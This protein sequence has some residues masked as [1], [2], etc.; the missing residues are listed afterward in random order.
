MEELLAQDISAH[1][2]MTKLKFDPY[3]QK[4]FGNAKL[5]TLS[6][7]VDMFNK[8]NPNRK[9][10][11][12]DTLRKDYSEQYLVLEFQIA[13]NNGNEVTKAMATKLQTE[14]FEHWV[15]NKKTASDVFND[16]GF[17]FYF[18]NTR[19]TI[20]DDYV[21]V[22]NAKNPHHKTKTLKVLIDGFE[23]EDKLAIRLALNVPDGN[24]N[25]WNLLFQD[26]VKRK[27]NPMSVLV[28]VFK[29]D[30]K[31]LD[32][33]SDKIKAIIAEYKPFYLEK[34]RVDPDWLPKNVDPRRL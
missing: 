31:K 19:L 6:D 17:Q 2:V 15:K 14:L 11:L 3:L 24:L 12:I 26:W 27:L 16:L 8:K 20:L 32:D 34:K 25:I 1:Y 10:S 13:K 5:Q 21:K 33:A 7:Y 23:G 22:L 9:T 29:V 4:N 18:D 30:E 28:D